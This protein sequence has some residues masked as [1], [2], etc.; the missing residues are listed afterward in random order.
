M[1]LLRGLFGVCDINSSSD[2]APNLLFR[3]HLESNLLRQFIEKDNR[4][5]RF[6]VPLPYVVTDTKPLEPYGD[7]QAT[8]DV[9]LPDI[10]PLN[11]FVCLWPKQ[12]YN[13]QQNFPIKVPFS[14]KY[15]SIRVAAA[16]VQW[17]VVTYIHLHHPRVQRNYGWEPL[18]NKLKVFRVLH[19]AIIKKRR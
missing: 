13:P 5:L 19:Y 16:K 8:L 3:L 1:N 18:S 10:S 17:N 2:K 14:A 6:F 11:P 7:A 9:A 15:F 12:V 4:L